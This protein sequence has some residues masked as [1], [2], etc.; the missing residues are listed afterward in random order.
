MSPEDVKAVRSRLGCTAK[1]LGRALGVEAATVTAWE[2]GELFPTK[3]H[4]EALRDLDA[5]GPGAVPRA[6]GRRGAA[7]TPAAV[8]ADP[9]VWTVIRKLVAHAE[10]R[11]AV[12]KLSESYPDPAEG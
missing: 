2:R 11:E 7:A 6:T 12:V 3:K 8:L 4:V 10:L 5:R 9:R 1:E